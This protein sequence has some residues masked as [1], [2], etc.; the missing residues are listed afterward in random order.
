MKIISYT[1]IRKKPNIYRVNTR[2]KNLVAWFRRVSSGVVR[3]SMTVEACI[4]VPLFIFCM[5]NLLFYIQVIETSSRMT[6]ALHETGNEICS[7]GY[8]ID[9]SLG[10]GFPSGAA[11]TVYA[12]S[13]IAKHLGNTTNHRGGIQGGLLG[14]N[15]LGSSIMTDNGLVKITTGYFLKFPV[16]MGI[17]PFYLGNIYYGHAWVGYEPIAGNIAEDI[18]DPIVYMTPSGSVYHTT[19]NC[20][21]LNPK[22]RS[23]SRVEAETIRSQDGS[24]YHQCELCGNGGG[25]G[26]VYVTD[27]GNRYHSNLYC[28]G[29]KRNVMCVHL[30]EVGGRRVCLTCGG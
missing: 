4:V 7:Y 26:S 1:K 22:V 5:I 14:I 9:N 29:I 23:V 21:H 24:I 20:S 18:E 8:A 11:S 30:S 25:M 17:R 13:S 16:K 15:Y 12:S 10:E 19:P 6:A 27:Y 2:S 28:S 3:G